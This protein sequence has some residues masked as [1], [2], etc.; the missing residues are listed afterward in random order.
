[1]ESKYLTMYKEG[2]GLKHF[3]FMTSP[4]V[5]FES[6]DDQLFLSIDNKD[7][8]HQIKYLTTN[9]LLL[10]ILE[11]MAKECHNSSVEAAFQMSAKKIKSL[12][13]DNTHDLLIERALALLRKTISLYWG[14]MPAH[15]TF[16]KTQRQEL[17]C[18]CKGLTYSDLKEFY[19]QH[20]GDLA[21]LYQTTEI[22]GVCGTCFDQVDAYLIELEDSK[23]E[24]YGLHKKEW[25]AKIRDLLDE[26]YLV[27]PP[28]FERHSFEFIAISSRQIKL[29]CHRP[30][31]GLN[32]KI[33]QDAIN[34]FFK[35][36]LKEEIPISVII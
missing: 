19:K 11:E 18:R 9:P 2:M 15:M 34:N 27:C 31:N 30:D 16:S 28:E 12:L 20:K 14:D 35:G 26:F 21:L 13:P 32:R 22:A 29:R 33:I 5:G 8:I 1:M 4:T 3:G 24:V 6:Q 7:F 17:L 36:Q 23:E 10:S 25:E